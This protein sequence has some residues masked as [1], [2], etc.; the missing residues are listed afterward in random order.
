MDQFLN[1]HLSALEIFGVIGA[2]GGARKP[3]IEMDITAVPILLLLLYTLMFIFPVLT[4][5]NRIPPCQHLPRRPRADGR[6]LL[7]EH[8]PDAE[9]LRCR[10]FLSGSVF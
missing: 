7:N 8:L 9:T 3:R 4:T 1:E 6:I 2:Q 5:K 10:N